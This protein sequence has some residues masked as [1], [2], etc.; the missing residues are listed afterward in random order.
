[1]ARAFLAQALSFDT[2]QDRRSRAF[3]TTL[4]VALLG[5]GINSGARAAD[6]TLSNVKLDFGAIK[7]E[8]PKLEVRGTPLDLAGVTSLFDATSPEAAVA[9]FSRLNATSIIIPELHLDV[10]IG[11][12]KDRTTYT[13][14]TASD[15]VAGRI[16]KMVTASTTSTSNDP[17]IGRLEQKIGLTTIEGMD[18]T[19]SAVFLTEAA[20]PGERAE[21]R[22]LYK[23]YEISDY[24]MQIGEI[25][26]IKLATIKARDARARAGETPLIAM[27]PA[28][29]ELSKK[30]AEAGGKTKDAKDLTKDEMKMVA[31]LFGLLEN[32][33]YGDMEAIGLTGTFKVPDGPLD[34]RLA[35]M[36]FSDKAG[37]GEFRLEGL[38]LKGGPVKA[39]F[40]TFSAAGFSFGSTMKA[41]AEAFNSGSSESAIAANPLKLIPKLGS[42]KVSGLMIEAPD[43]QT[44]DAAGKPEITKIGLRSSEIT[45]GAQRDGI[46]TAIKYTIDGLSMP[47]SPREKRDG[48]KDIAALG[49]TAID[50]SMGVEGAWTEAKNEFDISNL[51]LSGVGM[52]SIGITGLL[53]SITK[54]VFSGDPALTQVALLGASAQKLDIKVQD[55]GL[56]ARVLERDAKA[57]KK[58]A[59][60]LRK[61]FGTVAAVGLPAILGPSDG[62]KAIAAALSRFVAK[63]GTL[64][65]S[66]AAKSPSG[67]GLADVIAISSPQE[68]FDKLDV[69][70]SAE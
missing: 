54:D 17:A 34:F 68:I 64:S 24:S 40:G 66:A 52:G 42:V 45:V 11:D 15:I 62:A 12:K 20:K 3:T 2:A 44:R 50:M 27:L 39:A 9:R 32:F 19:A 1:M 26:T 60:E 47:I 55:K 36:F 65:V 38:D 46:P 16:G 30:Q 22:S 63:P 51:S 10:L 6:H 49:Y 14:T 5:M 41:L 53:G 18:L 70:A 4:M 8:I 37:Q 23:N 7:V 33:E 48:L 21:F 31:G 61:E 56:F 57:R 35:R 59:E 29:M 43:P 25:G 67:I 28:I 58:T 13:N 69:K